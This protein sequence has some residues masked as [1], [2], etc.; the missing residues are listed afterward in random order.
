MSGGVNNQK[1]PSRQES[2][3]RRRVVGLD[4]SFPMLSRARHGTVK[5]GFGNIVFREADA[6]R[7]PLRDESV[8]IALVNGIFNLNVASRSFANLVESCSVAAWFIRRC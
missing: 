3:L 2:E 6:E 8:E 5:A 1:G 4:S 7:L